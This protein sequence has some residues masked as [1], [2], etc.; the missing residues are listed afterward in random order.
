VT[1]REV[2]FNKLFLNVT[3]S[4][5]KTAIFLINFL[6]FVLLLFLSFILSNLMYNLG[7]KTTNYNK[8]VAH[9]DLVKSFIKYISVN[10]MKQS[11]F[12]SCYFVLKR[13]K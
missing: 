7:L 6:R 4:L 9:C 1:V 12:T 8:N 3:R 2:M 10:C 11:N 5:I 13:L